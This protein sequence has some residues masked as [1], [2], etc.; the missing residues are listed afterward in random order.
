MAKY[1][2]TLKS[3]HVIVEAKTQQAAQAKLYSEMLR[4]EVRELREPPAPANDN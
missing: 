4:A 1:L 2:I 3:G